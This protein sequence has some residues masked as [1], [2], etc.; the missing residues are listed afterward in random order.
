VGKEYKSISFTGYLYQKVGKKDNSKGNN[1][2]NEYLTKDHISLIIHL[3]W[4][5][6]YI[7]E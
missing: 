4:I 7:L 6:L 1:A 3:Y 2:N 5:H